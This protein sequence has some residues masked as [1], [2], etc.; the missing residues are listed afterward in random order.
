LRTP[1]ARVGSANAAHCLAVVR[2]SYNSSVSENTVIVGMSGGVD[3]AV[4][5]L[6][7]QQQGFDVQGLYMSNW[8]EDDQYCSDAQDYQDARRV[9]ERLK[10]PLHRM[11]FAKEYR[12]RVFAT[13]LS[14]YR[15]GRTPNPDVICNREI[16][17]GVCFD[18]MRRLGATWIATGHYA[19][20]DQAAMPPRLLKALDTAKDQSYFLHGVNGEALQRSRFPIGAMTKPAVR[21]L[22]H[23]A[24]LIVHDKPDSTGICFIGERPFREFLNKYVAADPGPI[25]TEDGRV[26][27][28]H[29]GLAFYTLGQR[30]GLGIGGQ[31]KAAQA[32]WYVADKKMARNCLV[33]VQRPDHPL[34]SSTWFDVATPTWQIPAPTADQ[35]LACRVKT[36]YRQPDL[37][38]S[39]H[40]QTNGNVRVHL[41]APAS[42]VTP[43]QYGVFYHG[44]H[45][46]GGGVI[47]T[48]G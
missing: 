39:L 11:S 38:A 5:A 40:I 12:E 26:I 44:D 6:L 21:E 15:A 8:D 14:E 7:L 34:L 30:S 43:G 17:F 32:P 1:A 23:R 36:R 22:A 47:Q 16:K 25:E 3:S 48:R 45:C 28:E 4:S 31:A 33:V 42:A 2:N 19:R 29:Q 35:R 37:P 46:L 41:D 18:F 20:V 13:F 24:G 9:A 10:I 27:G